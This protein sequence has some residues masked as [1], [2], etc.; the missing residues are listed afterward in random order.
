MDT[1]NLLFVSLDPTEFQ[2]ICKVLFET[3][4]V[5]MYAEDHFLTTVSFYLPIGPSLF[6]HCV[7]CHRFLSLL[8]AKVRFRVHLLPCS[9]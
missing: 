5:E 3:N 6:C 9:F 1:T 4:F 7:V 2:Y 8:V